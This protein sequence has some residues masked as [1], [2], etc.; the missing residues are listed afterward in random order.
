[1]QFAGDLSWEMAE[2]HRC[3]DPGKNALISHFPLSNFVG[4]NGTWQWCERIQDSGLARLQLS[5]VWWESLSVMEDHYHRELLLV[6]HGRL[7]VSR[8]PLLVPSY[9][10]AQSGA[11]QQKPRKLNVEIYLSA[12][13]SLLF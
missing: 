6:S 11:R 1:M 13:H 10:L 3:R 8:G 5:P 2:P 4:A 7:L 12:G 9:D